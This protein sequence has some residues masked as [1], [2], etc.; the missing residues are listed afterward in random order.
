MQTPGVNIAI[1]AP[2]RVPWFIAT[3]CKYGVEAQFCQNEESIFSRRF[4]QALDA[5][6]RPPET[7]VHWAEEERNALRESS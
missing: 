4:G 5:T 1:T 6:P 2:I 3:S 7:A